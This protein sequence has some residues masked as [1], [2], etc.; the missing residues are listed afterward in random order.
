MNINPLGPIPVSIEKNKARSVALVGPLGEAHLC[1]LPAGRV[2]IDVFTPLVREPTTFE[3]ELAVPLEGEQ[4]LALGD[5]EADR[6]T[7]PIG[8]RL[9]EAEASG[10]PRLLADGEESAS[11]YE[12][13]AS[14]RVLDEDKRR[15]LLSFEGTFENGTFRLAPNRRSLHLSFDESGSPTGAWQQEVRSNWGAPHGREFFPQVEPLSALPFPRT[16]CWLEIRAPG[17]QPFLYYLQPMLA[18][19]TGR[20]LVVPLAR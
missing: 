13:D 5:L 6:E 2:R 3:F 14:V 8:L 19:A 10:E 12:G 15:V 18:G 1:D 4:L 20:S 16:G 9:D 7:R 11:T 17:H